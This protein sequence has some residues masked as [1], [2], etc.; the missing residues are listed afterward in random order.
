M[1]PQTKDGD[2]TEQNPFLVA[3]TIPARD[4]ENVKQDLDVIGIP[5]YHEPEIVAGEF[6]DYDL[7]LPDDEKTYE[8]KMCGM[9]WDVEVESRGY[10]G[11][12]V[13]VKNMKEK[14]LLDDMESE[15]ASTAFWTL[16]H[17]I[18]H[19]GI[20]GVSKELLSWNENSYRIGGLYRYAGFV[21]LER[22]WNYRDYGE[23]YITEYGKS[24]EQFHREDD[25][26]EYTDEAEDRFGSYSIRGA[27]ESNSHAQSILT[28]GDDDE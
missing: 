16:V 23:R 18:R 22:E 7:W 5:S 19:I 20:P 26:K 1:E 25:T 6:G 9:M 27:H 4:D 8:I 14:F 28:A 15:Q 13:G 10:G 12:Q 24:L 3:D 21:L 2:V 11:A 17:F